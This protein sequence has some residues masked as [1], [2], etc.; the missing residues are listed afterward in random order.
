M[1]HKA[2]EGKCGSVNNV[3][4]EDGREVGGLGWDICAVEQER[5]EK[6][7]KPKLVRFESTNP[8]SAFEQDEE[9]ELREEAPRPSDKTTLG[10]V[11]KIKELSKKPK[12]RTTKRKTLM[13]VPPGLQQQQ[14]EGMEC[15]MCG[16]EGGDHQCGWVGRCCEIGNVEKERKVS[17][18]ERHDEFLNALYRAAREQTHF[19]Y[20]SQEDRRKREEWFQELDRRFVDLE[21]NNVEARRAQKGWI[22]IDSG[23]GESVWPVSWI[24]DWRKV[25]ESDESRKGV[26]F[27]AANGGR[28]ENFG[29]TK[30]EFGNEGK[31]RSMGFHVTEVKKP[32]AAVSRIIDKGNK[33]QFGPKDEDNFIENIRTGERIQMRRENGTFAIEVDFAEGFARLG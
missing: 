24:G 17:E 3:E 33:V 19:P 22:T 10:E 21:V 18:E 32:L 5:K 31:A 1:G 15:G 29:K 25:E 6:A 8:W 9:E 4:E 30:I 20:E 23:A 12:K 2:N 14:E 28:M 13:E 11:A 7:K 26:G 16:V 27:V